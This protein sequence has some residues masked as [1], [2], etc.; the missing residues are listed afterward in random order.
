MFSATRH[1]TAR[2]SMVGSMTKDSSTNDVVL[3]G[4][5]WERMG[6]VLVS[7]LLATTMKDER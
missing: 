5:F 2:C 7:V 4:R 1:G 3:V 6:F